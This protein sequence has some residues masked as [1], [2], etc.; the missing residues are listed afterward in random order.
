[1]NPSTSN[2]ACKFKQTD[3][4]LAS[5]FNKVNCAILFF[6]KFTV[7]IDIGATRMRAASYPLQSEER[8]LYNQIPTRSEGMAI[9]DRLINL[10]ESV[11]SKDHHLLSIAAACPGPLD[12]V[13]GIVI[14]PP[15]IPEWKYFPLQEFLAETYQV[16]VGV[17]NDANLAALG[18]WSFGAGKGTSDLIYFTI[19]TGI[20]G[21]IILNNKLFTGYSGF[22]A[23]LGHITL[24]HNGPE[25][26]CGKFGHLEAFASGPSIVRWIKSR[27][28][29][30]TLKEHFP[31]GALDAKLISDAAEMG[32][33][34]A[35]AAYDRAG[36]Y[37]AL[38]I[39]NMLHIFNPAMI[40][41]GG[42]VSRSGDLLF[43]PIQEYLKDFVLSEVY[44]ENLIIT[45]AALGDDSGLMGALV[46]SR[47]LI[48]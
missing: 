37:I 36:K 41:I 11:L 42:G 9:E 38:A 6:M 33:E 46:Y 15:N 48:I 43:D 35:I 24:V 31:D 1:L 44:I 32:N 26:T 10:I 21:G 39:A 19:S 47:E 29:D 27:L 30:E 13:N 16:P 12:P 7:A 23:E 40:I 2:I 22:G 20:G 17:N 34:L 14:E 3:L 5:I 25:C 8:I 28:E 45:P 4:M 18:E